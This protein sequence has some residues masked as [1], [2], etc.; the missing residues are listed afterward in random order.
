MNS[1]AFNIWF[2]ANDLELH[3]PV[4]D[5][6]VCNHPTRLI[7]SSKS[8]ITLL[9]LQSNSLPSCILI[10]PEERNKLTHSEQSLIASLDLAEHV[11]SLSDK[12]RNQN[13]VVPKIIN[14]LQERRV[15]QC[16]KNR[17]I[18]FGDLRFN[19]VSHSLQQEGTRD[20][21]HLSRIESKILGYLFSKP[22]NKLVR[23]DE[24][25]EQVWEGSIVSPRTL[26]S[27]VSRLRSKLSSTEVQI[28]SV[29]GKGYQ[30]QG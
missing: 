29:Y 17:E 20:R 16:T 19:P 13:E 15:S 7:R 24:L 2:V 18:R 12:K 21:I 11:L 30:I 14:W 28:E 27:H 1:L 26:D 5:Y 25:A 3:K 9:R 22:R 8:L 4:F 6:L 23:K 10:C